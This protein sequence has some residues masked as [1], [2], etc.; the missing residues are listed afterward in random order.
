MLRIPLSEAHHDEWVMSEEE[1][2][3]LDVESIVQNIKVLST[4]WEL[5]AAIVN[6][7]INFIMFWKKELIN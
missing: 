2:I 6:Y 7:Q 3:K 4:V 1:E 5:S